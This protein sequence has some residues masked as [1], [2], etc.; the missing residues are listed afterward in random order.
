[1]TLE[2]DQTSTVPL[3]ER[4]ILRQT[5]LVSEVLK[6]R[7]RQRLS[8][9]ISG[10]LVNRYVPKAESSSLHHVPNIVIAH[11][12]VFLSVMKREIL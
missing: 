2:A 6:L 7:L 4:G 3:S 12:N 5:K 1:M 8:Q 9:H 11:L 10:L